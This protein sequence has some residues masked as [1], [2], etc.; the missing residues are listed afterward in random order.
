MSCFAAARRSVPSTGA[1]NSKPLPMSQPNTQQTS[2]QSLPLFTQLPFELRHQIWR[3][4]ARYRPRIIQIFYDPIAERWEACKDG[5]G[6]LTPMLGVSQEARAEALKRYTEVFDTLFD[7]QEDTL[8][9]SGPIFSL[10]E[11][12]K[13][14]RVLL[15]MEC[16]QLFKNVALTS[17]YTMASQNLIES[18]PRYAPHR[19]RF[20]EDWINWSISRWFYSKI[21]CVLNMHSK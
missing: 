14:R 9:T 16:M 3:Y 13:Q 15:K 10:Q 1:Q 8:F 4:A 2:E 17:R 18:I 7:L 12:T 21:R 19:L 6:R 11:S 20:F 5:R